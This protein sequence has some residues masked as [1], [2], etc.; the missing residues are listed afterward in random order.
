M[1]TFRCRFLSFVRYIYNS[2]IKKD[3]KAFGTSG[4]PQVS[5]GH[6]KM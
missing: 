1:D 2:I 4:M 6:F 5:F 3:E